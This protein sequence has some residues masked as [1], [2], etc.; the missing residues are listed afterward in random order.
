MKNVYYYGLTLTYYFLIV[1]GAIFIPSVDIIFEFVGVI[2]GVS[3]SFIFPAVFYI[4][5]DMMYPENREYKSHGKLDVIH[6]TPPSNKALM[7]SAY[8]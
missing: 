6:G 2:C 3:L 4:Y 5:G 7:F 1:F 8:L